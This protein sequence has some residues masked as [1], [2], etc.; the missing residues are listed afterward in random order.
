MKKKTNPAPTAP[1][2]D[3]QQRTTASPQQ[4]A[5]IATFSTIKVGPRERS[6]DMRRIDENGHPTAHRQQ[7]QDPGDIK[8]S[9]SA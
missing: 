3:Q 4:D 9:V 1:P 8:E 7:R 2:L 5:P 6:K